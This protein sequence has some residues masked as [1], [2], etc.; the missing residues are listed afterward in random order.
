[1]ITNSLSSCRLS[2]IMVEFRVRTILVLGYWVL[3]NIH[4]YWVVLLS[5]DIFCCSDTQYNTNQRAVSAVHMPVNDYL[6]PL[7]TCTLTDTIVCLDIML[8]YCCLLNTIIVINSSSYSFGIF[9]G[10]C[11]ALYKYRY[12]Y[13][14]LVS[15]DAN[16][17]G[18]WILGA[19]L[20]I[21]LTLVEFQFLLLHSS[22]SI[23]RDGQ[24][25]VTD[26]T[27]KGISPPFTNIVCTLDVCNCYVVHIPHLQEVSHSGV[28][29]QHLGH[30][31]DNGLHEQCQIRTWHRSMP[32]DCIVH[33]RNAWYPADKTVCV[34]CQWSAKEPSH[35][36]YHRGGVRHH[37]LCICGRMDTSAPNLKCL[38]R[39]SW[40]SFHSS[41]T[42]QFC[43]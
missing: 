14:V 9:R 2:V 6:V 24:M 39:S 23:Q 38:K 27:G 3:G 11:Y 19:F 29:E 18:Y 4:R 31:A 28:F 26:D 7:L 16:I 35:P 36:A 17:I 20:G 34:I 1:M 42:T 30:P 8:I 43:N 22:G 10:H 13:W 25:I 12:W 32:S 41:R 37:D 5:G 15:L 40:T 33:P 21:V